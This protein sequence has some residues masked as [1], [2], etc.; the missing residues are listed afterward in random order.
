MSTVDS[1]NITTEPAPTGTSTGEP[2]DSSLPEPPSIPPDPYPSDPS[3]PSAPS[4]VSPS[5]D[6]RPKSG[7]PSILH[8]LQQPIFSIR[9]TRNE[10]PP[11][12][13]TFPPSSDE[14]LTIPRDLASGTTSPS[15]ATGSTVRGNLAKHKDGT[16]DPWS[17]PRDGFSTNDLNSGRLPNTDNT[18]RHKVSFPDLKSN[19]G[20]DDDDT[21]SLTSSPIDVPTVKHYHPLTRL[22]EYKETMVPVPNPHYRFVA[23]SSRTRTSYGN[24]TSQTSNSSPNPKNE[25]DGKDGFGKE[26][27]NDDDNDYD[28]E[29]QTDEVWVPDWVASCS[30]ETQVRVGEAMKLWIKNQRSKGLQASAF[31]CVLGDLT[32]KNLS[33]GLTQKELKDCYR[34]Y[35]ESMK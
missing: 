29:N 28:D 5:A 17:L 25:T 15:N 23:K 9:S 32:K 7:I 22:P 19:S 14:I 3:D 20:S 10:P 1:S 31:A 27:Q 30:P 21:K 24:F 35:G 26:T 4:L 6:S 11:E 16:L 2:D 34:A 13:N 8:L 12:T 18:A 33:G